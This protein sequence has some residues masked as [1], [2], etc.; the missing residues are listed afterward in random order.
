MLAHKAEDEGIACVEHIIG[1]GGHVNY[2]T[3]PGVI[4]TYP[5]VG[6]VGKT[7][8]ELKKAGIL[9]T[10]KKSKKII[11]LLFLPYSISST[12]STE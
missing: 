6:S 11:F 8:E 4:Y 10:L 12:C 3:I 5:E 9:I 1:E 7:E 2:D